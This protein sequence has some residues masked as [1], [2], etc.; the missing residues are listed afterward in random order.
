MPAMNVGPV[1]M[2]AAPQHDHSRTNALGDRRLA[3]PSS[4]TACI[5]GQQRLRT[6]LAR[7]SSSN[8]LFWRPTVDCA[9]AWLGGVAATAHFGGQQ[10]DWRLTRSGSGNIPRKPLGELAGRIA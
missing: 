9:S 6:R 3:N 4:A 5:D 2:G 1:V 8:A 7:L 10:C